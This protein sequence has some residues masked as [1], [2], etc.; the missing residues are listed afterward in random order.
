MILILEGMFHSDTDHS[1]ASALALL[2]VILVVLGG[3]QAVIL[4]RTFILLLLFLTAF[5]W[6]R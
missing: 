3:I 4:P 2:L 6:I 5:A 1:F